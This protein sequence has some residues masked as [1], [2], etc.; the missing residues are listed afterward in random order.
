[1][2][3]VSMG[4]WLAEAAFGAIMQP[5][6]SAQPGSLARFR[7]RIWFGILVPGMEDIPPAPPAFDVWAALGSVEAFLSVSLLG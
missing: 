5:R 2:R 3:V 7:A 6:N 1:M 4:E